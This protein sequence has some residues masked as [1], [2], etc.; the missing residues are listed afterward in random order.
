VD[1]DEPKP[2]RKRVR[3]DYAVGKGRPPRETQFQKGQSGNPG[4]RPKK[5]PTF[6]EC[7]QEAFAKEV[8]TTIE[9]ER[10]R[11]PVAKV[12]ATN[13]ISEAAKDQHLLIKTIRWLEGDAPPAPDPA[14]D[15]D[16]VEADD[17]TVIDEF[18]KRHAAMSAASSNPDVVDPE[19]GDDDD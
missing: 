14:N 16:A 12:L 4:G 13:L 9:G 5:Q 18:L 11:V 2:P 3:G 8:W 19:N 17:R 6:R 1:N 10:Q 15:Q 7:L